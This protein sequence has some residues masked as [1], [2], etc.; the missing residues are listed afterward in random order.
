MDDPRVNGKRCSPS[1]IAI[2]NFTAGL[3]PQPQLYTIE[4]S[5][6]PKDESV[7]FDR[8]I[9]LCGYGK[10]HYELVLLCGL[11]FMSAGFQNGLNAYILPSAACDLQLS[12]EEKGLLNVAF[13]AGGTSSAMLWGIIADV[14]G[15]KN[16]LLGTLIA[17][18]TITIISSLSQSFQTLF[19]FRFLNGFVIGA[20][21]CLVF[22]YLGEFHAEKQ[23]AKS[24][25]Y[26]G[27]FFTLAWLVLPG[28]AWAIIPMT[29]E[30]R[31]NGLQFNSWRLFVALVG[32]PTVISS[33]LLIRFPE[34]PKF[35]VSQ[36][37]SKEALKILRGIFVANTS[38]SIH[39]YPVKTLLAN[40]TAI[41]NEEASI[42]K[43]KFGITQ[44]L[45]SIW[46]QICYL[47]T[48]PLL[49]YA[50][51]FSIMLFANMFGY[52]GLGLWLPELF[53]RFETYYKLHPNT[54]VT[55]CELATFSVPANPLAEAITQTQNVILVGNSTA[56]DDILKGIPCSGTIDEQVFVNTLTVNAVSLLGNVASGYLADRLGRRTMPVGTMVFAGVFG[57]SIYFLRSASQNL[58]VAC[59]FSTFI[60]TGNTVL[61]S[62]IVDIFPTHVSAMAICL[63]T[64]S[65]RIGAIASNLLFGLLL[66]INCGV[67]IFLVGGVVIFGGLL[68]FLIPKKG[69]ITNKYCDN[70]MAVASA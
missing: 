28:L 22:S 6:R 30:L 29:F 62:V 39:D 38:H 49:K 54:T 63:A 40:D 56:S 27:F 33:I 69:V 36:G 60:A 50:V 31:I 14:F 57:C 48:P 7:E 1:K 25:C 70:N 35:L 51:L 41:V 2:G 37:K 26:V 10:Y 66:D 59:L 3:E 13:L 32:I 68:G 47:F 53:N 4:K 9:T 17:D 21:G 45:Q 20:P 64:L 16:I 19:V 55:V 65:G 67:P 8:A 46:K 15:R 23:R 24:I 18:G 11:I 5:E 58:I 61:N 44:L 34:S 43:S 12:S 42:E 52:Y